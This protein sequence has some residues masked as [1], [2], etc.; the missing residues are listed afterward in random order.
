MYR[1]SLVFLFKKFILG[2]YYVSINDNWEANFDYD[3][4]TLQIC[5]NDCKL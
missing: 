1:I 3:D 4:P 2:I 5:E